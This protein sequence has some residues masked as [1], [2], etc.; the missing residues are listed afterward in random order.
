MNKG[1]NELF[2]NLKN[3]A[4]FLIA[5]FLFVSL[6]CNLPSTTASDDQSRIPV[7]EQSATTLENNA[8]QALQDLLN[9]QPAVLNINETELTS[10]VVYRLEQQSGGAISQS[11]VFLRDGL[12]QYRGQFQQSPFSV[13]VEA[14]FRVSASPEGRLSYEVVNATAGP[15]GNIDGMISSFTS[16]FDEALYSSNSTLNTIFIDQVTIANGL[17]TISGR[18]R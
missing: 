18:P 11:Q 13:P 7:S 10:L 8:S 5:I 17:M 1:V 12:I 9:G 15:F 6:A 3:V 4:A 16:Q 2:N 14:D